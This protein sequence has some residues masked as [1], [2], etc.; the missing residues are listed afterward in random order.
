MNR[1]R[2]WPREENSVMCNDMPVLRALTLFGLLASI[3]SG[4]SAKAVYADEPWAR[5]VLRFQDERFELLT[6]GTTH[7][8]RAF[9]R[10]LPTTRSFCLA[11][12]PSFSQLRLL[13][14]QDRDRRWMIFE[15]FDCHRGA[16]EISGAAG[17][18]EE[19][20]QIVRLFDRTLERRS[21]PA[22]IQL[23]TTWDGDS[24][25]LWFRFRHAGRLFAGGP[26]NLFELRRLNR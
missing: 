2:S 17:S 18:L 20:C 23:R 10:P 11:R 4:P 1:H 5:D 13:L 22:V 9:T 19:T 24:G 14:H 26:M 8:P 21:V 25:G 15:I 12:M 6:C 7:G 16:S 3:L